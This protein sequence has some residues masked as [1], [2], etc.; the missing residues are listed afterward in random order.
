MPVKL[1]DPSTTGVAP[2]NLPDANQPA[3]EATEEVDPRNTAA[4]IIRQYMKRPGS[5]ENA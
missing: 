3:G 2:Q 1:P 4:D 5:D